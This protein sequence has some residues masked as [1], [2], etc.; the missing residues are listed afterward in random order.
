MSENDA[1]QAE[2]EITAEADRLVELLYNLI[3]SQHTSLLAVYTALVA[4]LARV[5]ADLPQEMDA[6]LT[7]NLTR[8]LPEL[9]TLFRGRLR[10][11]AEL[12]GRETAH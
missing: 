7:E 6:A 2:A 9:V 5:Y 3:A 4:L 10:D 11:F 8:R 1:A 12:T